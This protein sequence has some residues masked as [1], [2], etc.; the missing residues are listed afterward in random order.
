LVSSM[1]S[2]RL[3]AS[4]T[5]AAY[6]VL[7]GLPDGVSYSATAESGTDV[8]LPAHGRAI[9]AE[10]RPSRCR[11]FRGERFALRSFRWRRGRRVDDHAIAETRTRANPDLTQVAERPLDK[12]VGESCG[13]SS[14][15]ALP[16][17]EGRS[18]EPG[19]HSR[20]A[21]HP[22]PSSLPPYSSM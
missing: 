6:L 11:A 20:T 9:W 5:D 18:G 16:D 10:V 12:A 19:L 17:L 3:S 14:P 21:P 8:S 1:R 15:L 2:R 4:H 7:P 22:P 13:C